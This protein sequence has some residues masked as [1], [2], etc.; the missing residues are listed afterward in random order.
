MMTS[1]LSE[2]LVGFLNYRLTESVR[3]TGFDRVIDT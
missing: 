2:R 3:W 1:L